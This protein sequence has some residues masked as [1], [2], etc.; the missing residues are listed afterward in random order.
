MKPPFLTP[1]GRTVLRVCGW[2]LLA[3]AILAASIWIL[4]PVEWHKFL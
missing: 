1:Y 3:G 2:S 4:G